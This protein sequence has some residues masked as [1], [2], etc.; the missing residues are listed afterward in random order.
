M[1]AVQYIICCSNEGTNGLGS[2]L[3]TV[4]VVIPAY[5]ASDS[6]ERTI[7]SVIGQPSVN[8]EIIVVEDGVFDNT[9]EFLEKYDSVKLITNARNMGAPYS[10]NV[11]L[12]N[13][14]NQ[15]VMFLD[16]DDTIEGP[17]LRGLCQALNHSS[18]SIAFGPWCICDVDGVKGG[19][20][21]PSRHR[22]SL[23][24]MDSW[25]KG[26]YVPTCSVLWRTSVVRSIGGWNEQ[27]SRNQDGEIMLR[28]LMAGETVAVS[29]EGCGVYWQHPINTSR[30]SQS[31][32]SNA[33]LSQ[34]FVVEQVVEWC[35]REGLATEDIF[36]ALA[37]FCYFNAKYFYR[38]GML[39]EGK[40]WLSSARNYGL[41]GHPGTIAHRVVASLL[42]LETK[43]R[44][45]RYCRGI[46]DTLR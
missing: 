29:D 10:R 2:K 43:E 17:L 33:S 11:G 7:S 28:A 21:A 26:Q 45:A 8:T 4:S 9:R 3:E 13:V 23:Q 34:R 41:K 44:F 16:A 19:V 1:K 30:V 40:E 38:K 37:E 25:L 39:D 5:K 42:S 27:M 14:S 18:D 6:I 46:I 24:W 35:R 15:Y 36:P 31:S 20:V 12:E 22:S 32:D